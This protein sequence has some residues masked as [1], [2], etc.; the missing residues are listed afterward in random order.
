MKKR[1]LSEYSPRELQSF[2]R[3]YE[4]AGLLEGG[5]YTLA[6]LKLELLRRNPSPKSP[7]E[8]FQFIVEHTG[9]HPAGNVTYGEVWSFLFPD[10][11]WQGNHSGK[12]VGNALGTVIAYSVR[13]GLPI[14]STLVVRSGSRRLSTQAIQNIY[15]EAKL[16]GVE[17]GL[18]PKEFVDREA[19]RSKSVDLTDLPND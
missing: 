12:T 8:I 14:V 11:E 4:D 19:Q 3:K 15:N 13:H 16:Y 7:R 10:A 1:E 6:E 2:I 18:S 9:K 17:V 5:V